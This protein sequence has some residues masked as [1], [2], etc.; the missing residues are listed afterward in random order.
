MEELVQALHLDGMRFREKVAAAVRCR[1]EAIED[2]EAVR[3]GTAL[4]AL[5]HMAPEG[6]RLIWETSDR[7]WRLLGDTSEDLNWY[8]KRATLSAVYAATVL[9]WLGD[10]SEGHAATWEF[11]D[12]RIE[13]VMRFEK[14]KAQMRDNPALS[15]LFAGPAALA[16]RIR[17]PG[18]GA[19]TPMPGRWGQR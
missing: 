9:Y 15:R 17:A 12:R 3:R 7:I 1:L 13:D 11:L 19:G 18:A 2:R 4:F 16:G 8:T 14:L 5:P 10:Q 6:A